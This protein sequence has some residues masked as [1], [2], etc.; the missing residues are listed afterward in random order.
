[1][2]TTQLGCLSSRSSEPGLLSPMGAATHLAPQGATGPTA[3]PKQGHPRLLCQ[4]WFCPVE[5][6]GCFLPQGKD[7]KRTEQNSVQN[8]EANAVSKAKSQKPRGRTTQITV[9]T[10]TCVP[11][12]HTV[13]LTRLPPNARAHTCHGGCEFVT[14]SSA[15]QFWA[16]LALTCVRVW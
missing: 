15:F 16:G 8:Q 1:M 4:R 6:Q 12:P 14:S 5:V 13:Q 9:P 2:G 3:T 11:P 10:V 7:D